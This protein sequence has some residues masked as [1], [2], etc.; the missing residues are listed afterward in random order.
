MKRIIFLFI[1]IAISISSMAAN[2]QKPGD[3]DKHL[4]A[5]F[6][7]A[8]F[9][10]PDAGSYLETYVYFDAWSLNFVK[11]G[12]KYQATIEM[13]ITVSK[14]DSLEVVKK[15]ELNS[16]KIDSPDKD[17]FNFIDMQRLSIPNG[18]H[19]LRITLHDKNSS[20]E[21]TVIE[22]QLAVYYD[23]KR[24]ALSSVQMMSNVKPTSTPNIMSR[25]G[26]DMEPYVSDFLP[27]EVESINYYYEL[28]NVN[29]ETR[30]D[31]VYAFAYIETQETGKVLELTQ[32]AQR[33]ENSSLIPVFGT[34]DIKMVP[35]GNYNLVVEIRN[36]HNDKLLYRRLPFM[37][38]NPKKIEDTDMMPVSSTFA[39]QINDETKL[40]DYI[41]GLAPIANEVERRDIYDLIR[42]PGIE[43]KQIFLYK[44]WTRREGLNAESAW[45]EYRDRID[46]VNANFGW[47]NTKG[48]QTDRGRVYLK[49]GPPD[50]VRDEKNFVSSLHIGS[51]VNVHTIGSNERFQVKDLDSPRTESQGQIFYLPYQLWRYNNIPGDDINRCFIFW[52][53]FRNGL[54][55]LLNSNAKGEVREAK[56][57]QRLSQQQLNEDMI[58]EVGE[59]FERGY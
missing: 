44:F 19:D 50:F 41:E 1:A 45:V 21:V 10:H 3:N 8:T 59:Q 9:F 20:D 31:Y 17:K 51:G 29:T 38:S 5:I 26:Y 16:P 55:K 33:L 23:M 25:N 48:I 54:Y 12:N 53:E 2:T 37:R 28:Y 42:K 32:S 15:Y 46:Y 7:Y 36:R 39:G 24:T 52:D 47:I 13:L 35:S 56:W 30:D 43:E 11:S 4:T 40:N 18:I 57:E 14:G 34:I 22:Q 58:G 6:S 49:Y 27:E